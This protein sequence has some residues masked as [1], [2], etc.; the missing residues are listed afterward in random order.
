[1]TH[2]G[3]HGSRGW[4]KTIAQMKDLRLVPSDPCDRFFGSVRSVVVLSMR[5]RPAHST[6]LSVRTSDSESERRAI[7]RVFHC[8]RPPAY[9]QL[10]SGD[11]IVEFIRLEEIHK[12]YTRGAIDVP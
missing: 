12:V 4:D 8:V 1:L 7:S 5:N 9:C 10:G 2:P 11:S 3:N 6:S